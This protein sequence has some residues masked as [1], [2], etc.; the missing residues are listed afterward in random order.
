MALVVGHVEARQRLQPL[1]GELHAHPRRDQ[2]AQRPV[3]AE[4]SG[5][6]RR[7]LGQVLGVVEHDQAALRRQRLQQLCDRVPGVVDISLEPLRKPGDDRGHIEQVLHLHPQ[8]AARKGGPASQQRLPRETALADA[9]RAEHG[10]HTAVGPHQ[11]GQQL[12]DLFAPTD[13]VAVGSGVELACGMRSRGHRN[14]RRIVEQLAQ[15]TRGFDA[16]LLGELAGVVGVSTARPGGPPELAFGAQQLGQ[17]RLVERIG[18][19]QLRRHLAAQLRIGEG[20]QMGE[21]GLM[22]ERCDSVALQRQPVRQRWVARIVDAGQQRPGAPV[23]RIGGPAFVERRLQH[24][25]VGVDPPAQRMFGCFDRLGSR[26]RTRAKDHLAQVAPRFGIA[27]LGPEQRSQAV[28]RNPVA[29]VQRQAG[30]QLVAALGQQRQG[31]RRAGQ[32]RCSEQAHTRRTGRG[33]APDFLRRATQPHP[34]FRGNTGGAD[35]GRLSYI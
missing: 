16:Q 31:R 26:Q 17:C 30:E 22:A 13:E 24:L 27:A 18:A 34:L 1:V 14:R 7:Q 25:Q 35:A 6:Q 33:H 8:G 12:G 20:L 32:H 5:Q 10:E 19:Q 2:Q 3:A 15:C 21:Q 9:A 11:Q 28:S 29:A 23:R 4:Q